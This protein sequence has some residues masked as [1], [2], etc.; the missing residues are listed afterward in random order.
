MNEYHYTG[1]A[2]VVGPR[3]NN[4]RKTVIVLATAAALTEDSPRRICARRRSGG[5]HGAVR[6]GATWA[7]SAALT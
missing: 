4:L 2:K 6:G 7:G 3:S 5:G 1:L